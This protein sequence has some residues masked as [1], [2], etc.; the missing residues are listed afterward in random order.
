MKV[1]FFIIFK[2]FFNSGTKGG[3]WVV[4]YSNLQ[5]EASPKKIMKKI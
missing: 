5:P 1:L 4:Y 2:I 3:F